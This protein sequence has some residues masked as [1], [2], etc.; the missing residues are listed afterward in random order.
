MRNEI[1]KNLV[2]GVG[3]SF[4]KDATLIDNQIEDFG[5]D[6]INKMQKA[7]NVE[8]GKMSLS[9]INGTVNEMLSA[10]AQFTGDINNV[11]T[12][13]GET[14]YENQQ[15]ITARKNLQYGGVR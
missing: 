15:K 8:T 3:V 13:D 11:L 5:D 10:N 7:V 2:L 12:L 6:V 14:I 4:E 1:G 9:G